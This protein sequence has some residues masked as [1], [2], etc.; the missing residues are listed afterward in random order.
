MVDF[1][2]TCFTF[3][4]AFACTQL[5]SPLTLRK[6]TVRS[7]STQ[8]T[9][10]FT[11]FFGASSSAFH[12]IRTLHAIAD[13]EPE[14]LASP[15][16]KRDFY[17]DDLLSGAHTVAGALAVQASLIDVLKRGGFEIRK[18]SSNDPA[19]LAHLSSDML[20]TTDKDFD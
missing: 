16:L 2:T 7:P 11:A 14:S 18:W 1:K 10:T 8:R 13:S 12:S 20:E 19:V 5:H 17:V 9:A 6:C 4:F 3:W 15:V